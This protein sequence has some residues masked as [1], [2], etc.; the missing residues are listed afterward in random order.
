[1]HNDAN[2][3]FFFKRYFFRFFL[4]DFDQLFSFDIFL[5]QLNLLY[6]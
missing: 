2:T 1:M 6:V 5:G 4:D 3:F